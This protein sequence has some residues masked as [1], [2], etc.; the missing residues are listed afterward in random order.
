[1]RT[2]SATRRAPSPSRSARKATATS[3]SPWPIPAAAWTSRPRRVSSSRSSPR[4][5]SARAP[6]SGSRWCAISSP[7]MTA[8]SRWRAPWAKAPVSTSSSRRRRVAR[9]PEPCSV[10]AAAAA[11]GLNADIVER[12]LLATLLASLLLAEPVRLHDLVALHFLEGLGQQRPATLDLPSHFGLR[13]RQLAAALD[14]LA[15]IGGIGDGRLGRG[16]GGRLLFR[17]LTIE[18]PAL[19]G[20]LRRQPFEVGEMTP[21]LIHLPAVEADQ[22]VE[23]AHRGAASS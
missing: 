9:P 1:P 22:A 3:T 8:G 10:L 5:K 13:L 7:R 4:K 2:P 15:G 16:G 11:E 21:A 23:R 6:A 17:L 14:Q 12:L 20:E 18:A 19:L